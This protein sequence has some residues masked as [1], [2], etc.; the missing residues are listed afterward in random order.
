MEPLDRSAARW[1]EL[2]RELLKRAPDTE[3]WERALGAGEGLLAAGRGEAL[4]RAAE[5]CESHGR[6]EIAELWRGLLDCQAA[7]HER[8]L[9][10]FAG[11]SARRLATPVPSLPEPACRGEPAPPE[12]A[13][14]LDSLA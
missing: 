10:R 6:G 7:D 3:L 11:L 1:R 12:A 13:K 2:E 5:R 8:A 14:P 9:T 4:S